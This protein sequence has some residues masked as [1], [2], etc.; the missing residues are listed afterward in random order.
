MTKLFLCILWLWLALPALAQTTRPTA[1]EVP[2]TVPQRAADYGDVVERPPLKGQKT[3]TDLLKEGYAILDY[4]L[5][6]VR[7]NRFQAQERVLLVKEQ[8]ASVYTCTF[9]ISRNEARDEPEKIS[10]C[11]P[12]R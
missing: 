10:V 4:E 6:T 8:A 9:Q 12:V 5:V 1:P 3:I 2:N 7:I 11:V